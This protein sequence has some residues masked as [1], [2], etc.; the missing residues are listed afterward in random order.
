MTTYD[1]LACCS[2]GSTSCEPIDAGAGLS[3]TNSSFILYD[4]TITACEFLMY[5]VG[6]PTG[7][8]QA[9]IWNSSGVV[10]S[11]SADVDVSTLTTSSSGDW[12][13]FTGL[14]HAGA[15]G[16]IIGVRQVSGT[17]DGS[18]KARVLFS[19]TTCASNTVKADISSAGVIC[20]FDGSGGCNYGNDWDGIGKFTY[21]TE[22]P[23][24]P[25][26]DTLLFPPPV[27]WI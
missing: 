14:S 21:S 11:T 17:I 20:L 24:P 7:N 5:K 10:Q 13:S 15:V 27:A 18:N 12:V 4:K 23:P 6:S 8:I 16:D 26:S 22:P 3:I 2:T 25:V 1:Q 19:S 9:T